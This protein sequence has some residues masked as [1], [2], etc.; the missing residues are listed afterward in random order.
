LKRKKR[1]LFGAVD[2]GYRIEHYTKFIQENFSDQ[3]IPESFSKFVLPTSQY[4]TNYTYTCRIDKMHPLILYAYS[5]CFFIFSLF[6][7]DIFHFISGETIL[8]RKLRRAELF[9]YKLFGKRVI[10]HFVGSDIRSE[11]FIYWKEKN[12]K[13]FLEQ[14]TSF[15]K[16]LPWQKKL[17]ADTEKYADF[18]LVSTP[19]LKQ[20][21]KNATYYPV[22]LDLDKFL[23]EAKPVVPRIKESDEI[24]ILHSPSNTALKGTV[25]IHDV[26]KKIV[27]TLPYNIK[28][29]LP[30]ERL[31]GTIK[32]YAVTR[33]ELFEIYKQADIVIDQVIIGWYGLQSIEALLMGKEVISYI[34]PELEGDLFPNCPIELATVNTLEQV[35]IKCIEKIRANKSNPY[36]NTVEWVKKYHAIEN[37]NKPLLDAWGVAIIKE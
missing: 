9:I 27:E 19:D 26:L 16:N 6:R 17:I 23:Q 20:F 30:G 10:M 25:H 22:V 24:V 3:L 31:M 14:G 29:I 32:T 35:I 2:I 33:Y 12:I 13:H 4:K 28:L 18:I 5:L 7:Y 36:K 1:I 15:E 37:N 21:L 8:T 11:E 34:D